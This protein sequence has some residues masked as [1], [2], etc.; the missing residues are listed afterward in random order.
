M[1]KHVWLS[2]KFRP[3]DKSVAIY[4]PLALKIVCDGAEP[5]A[6]MVIAWIGY[7]A[8]TARQKGTCRFRHSGLHTTDFIVRGWWTAAARTG[9]K[10][11]C[12][13]NRDNYLL[14]GQRLLLAAQLPLP[15]YLRAALEKA[16][17]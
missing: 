15:D 9:H 8:E 16:T 1:S 17:P 11:F 2:K 4:T 12:G 10:W 3:N 13:H 5:P 7:V 6:D 14:A